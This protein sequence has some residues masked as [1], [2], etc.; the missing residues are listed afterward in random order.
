VNGRAAKDSGGVVALFF[1]LSLFMRLTSG[2]CPTG[3]RKL[4]EIWLDILLPMGIG[5]KPME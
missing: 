1:R 5:T 3:Q 4:R 2:R